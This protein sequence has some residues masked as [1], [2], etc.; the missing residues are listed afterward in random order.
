MPN[1][2]DLISKS[3]SKLTDMLHNKTIPDIEDDIL[4]MNEIAI[5]L[6]KETDDIIN[7]CTFRLLPI[8][9]ENELSTI[10]DFTCSVIDLEEIL[11]IQPLGMLTEVETDK[12]EDAIKNMMPNR[13][14]LILPYSIKIMKTKLILR[15]EV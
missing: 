15:D 14:I 8:S 13:K 11:F 4:A 12:F 10:A 9:K 3:L 7:G 5:S 1:T 2:I 6:S